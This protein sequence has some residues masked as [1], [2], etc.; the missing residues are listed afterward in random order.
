MNKGKILEGVRK[1][2][3][4]LKSVD[5]EF[6]NSYRG[7]KNATIYDWDII[8]EVTSNRQYQTLMSEAHRIAKEGV[9]F[10]MEAISEYLR[11]PRQIKHFPQVRAIDII[12]C[13]SLFE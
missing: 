10:F 6:R 5:K 3:Q 12:K 9:H 7:Y 2:S 4:A 1:A 11:L 13:A 8:P